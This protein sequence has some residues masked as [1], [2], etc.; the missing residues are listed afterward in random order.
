MAGRT[1]GGLIFG[2][3]LCAT[4]LQATCS[5]LTFT[6]IDRNFVATSAPPQPTRRNR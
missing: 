1:Q 6:R 2:M 5:Q 4:L 3:V